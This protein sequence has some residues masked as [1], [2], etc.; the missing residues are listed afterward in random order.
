M[1]AGEAFKPVYD[2]LQLH[3]RNLART[4]EDAGTVINPL[5]P[6]SVC[7]V[8]I[9]HALGV[10]VLD[11]LPYAFFCYLCLILTLLFGFSGV[12]ISSKNKHN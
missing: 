5:V 10:A 9:S 6:W 2:K 3:P 1:L 4:L 7:G 11:Y 8:F 12:T